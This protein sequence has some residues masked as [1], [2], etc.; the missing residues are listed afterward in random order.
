MSYRI[1]LRPNYSPSVCAD[2]PN[3]LAQNMKQITELA[4]LLFCF[5][6]SLGTTWIPYIIVVK[7]EDINEVLI[8]CG[9]HKNGAATPRTLGAHNP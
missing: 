9:L 1:T 5:G 2:S 6:Y 3:A 4:E 8:V 7:V